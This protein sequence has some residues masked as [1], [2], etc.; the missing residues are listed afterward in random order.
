[1]PDL[2]EKTPTVDDV[3]REKSPLRS[4]VTDA[5]NDGVRSALQSMGIVFA[6][7][8]LTGAMAAWVGSRRSDEH[9]VANCRI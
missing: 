3:L 8:V 2:L 4:T 6:V 9:E 5:V 7:G 1:M